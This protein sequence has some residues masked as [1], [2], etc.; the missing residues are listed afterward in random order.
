MIV[1]SDASALVTLLNVGRLGLLRELY[2]R[3]LVPSAVSGEVLARGP[4]GGFPP[5]WIEIRDPAGPAPPETAGLGAGETAALTLA[6]E[7]SADA[8]VIDERRGRAVASALGL[9]AIGET[10]AFTD[11]RVAGTTLYLAFVSAAAFTLWNGLTRRYPVNILAGYR[12]LIPLCGVVQSALFISGESPG[13]GIYIGGS[14]VIAGIFL[15]SRLRSD[16][17]S[18]RPVR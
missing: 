11:V 13:A 10:A 12:F 6:R 9:P 17:V 18:P 16:A 7:L 15:I 2:A 8:V 5:D 14:I 3:V 4:V 1:V